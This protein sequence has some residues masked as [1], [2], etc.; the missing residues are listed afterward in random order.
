M[1]R[2]PLTHSLELALL[3]VVQVEILQSRHDCVL[4]RGLLEERQLPSSWI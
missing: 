3:A 1:R 4:S 2:T